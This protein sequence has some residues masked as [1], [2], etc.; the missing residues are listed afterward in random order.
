MT[1][2]RMGQHFLG[3]PGWQK[4]LFKT[5]PLAPDDV[6][7]EIG[8]G[9]GEL[10]QL[11]AANA[12]R[13]IAV[14]ADPRLA[15][16][17]RERAAREW[18]NVEVVLGDVLEQDLAELTDGK[19]R[20]YGNLPYYITSPILHRLFDCADRIESIHIVI[21]LEVAERIVAPP[22][23]HASRVSFSRVPVLHETSN[24]DANS[25]GRISSTAQGE[26]RAGE[27]DAPGRAGKLSTSPTKSASSN[28]CRRAL[29]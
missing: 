15:E 20:V 13:V 14:E 28:S 1:R 21:Q 5:L 6:W 9:H 27:N 4:K 23:G 22:G 19:F 16:G 11:L 24:C 7:I 10:T 18:A 25:A 26:I 2:Q 8:P 17:L 12:R 3:D 29:E